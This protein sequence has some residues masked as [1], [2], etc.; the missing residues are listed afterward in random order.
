MAVPNGE[1]RSHKFSVYVTPSELERLVDQARTSGKLLACY[2]REASLGARPRKKNAT[3]RDTVVH[4]LAR[5]GTRLRA[6]ARTATETGHPNAA[7]FDEALS[8]L[9]ETIRQI[10]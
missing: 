5:L 3:A 4:Y 9:L 10:E 8:E 6:V 1:R 7:D 2:V